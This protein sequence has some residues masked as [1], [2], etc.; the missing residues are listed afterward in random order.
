MSMAASTAVPSATLDSAIRFHLP[1]E[2]ETTTGRTGSHSC[3]P[4]LFAHFLETICEAFSEPSF[5]SIVPKLP[6]Q[7]A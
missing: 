5:S 1:A 4:F 3:D 2:E 7:L 6:C